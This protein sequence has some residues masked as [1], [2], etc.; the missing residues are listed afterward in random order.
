VKLHRRQIKNA[1]YNPR[2]ISDAAKKKLRENIRKVGIVAPIIWNKTTGNCLGGHQRL[3]VLDAL[4]GTDDYELTIAQVEMDA[5]TEKEQNVFLN[6]AAAQGDW[7]L[8]KLG[9]LF[10]D[11]ELDLEGTGFDLA[12]LHQLF[13][14]SPFQ[15]QPEELAALGE[16]VRQAREQYLGL[17]NRKVAT[18]DVDFYAVLVFE[19]NT[20]REAFSKQLGLSDNK[21]LDGRRLA[22]I[23][24]EWRQLKADLEKSKSAPDVGAVPSESVSKD[25]PKGSKK[26]A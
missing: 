23:I 3:A 14:D 9:A 12:E 8:E 17:V 13:G 22:E 10:K 25:K 26:P 4:E 19:G 2:V 6:N 18:D 11:G 5:K 15:E 1:E 16:R 21:F 20:E 7:D 24:G